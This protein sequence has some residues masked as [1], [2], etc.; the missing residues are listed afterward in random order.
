MGI[1]LVIVCYNKIILTADIQ[2]NILEVLKQDFDL[3]KEIF[4][5]TLIPYGISSINMKKDIFNYTRN[6]V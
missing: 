1:F 6:R 2:E 5:I 4:I 3:Y